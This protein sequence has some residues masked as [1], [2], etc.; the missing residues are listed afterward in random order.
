MNIPRLILAIVVAF[1]LIFATDVLI[2][3][4]W[5]KPDY[6]A[7]KAIWRPEA[8]MQAHMLW[9]TLAQVICALTFVVIWAKGFAGGSLRCGVFFGLIMGM[10]Q[11]IWVLVNYAILPMP[12][13]LAVKW[14]FS[15]LAQAILI[16]I[17]TALLYRPRQ[18]AVSE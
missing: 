11:Q 6:D 7:T 16:G 3:G 18:T 4:F 2:H 12:G 10:F 14:Y 5:L 15:G 13:D 8:E 17:S 1:L 9:L